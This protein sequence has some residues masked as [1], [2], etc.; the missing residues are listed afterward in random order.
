MI[1]WLADTVRRPAIS[2]RLM[3]PGLACGS[4]PVSRSTSAHIAWR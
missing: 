2:D 4:S 3:T 1:P